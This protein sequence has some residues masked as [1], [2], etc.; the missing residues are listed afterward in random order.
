MDLLRV[1]YNISYMFCSKTDKFEASFKSNP[2]NNDVSDVH[3]STY[4]SLTIL[5][6]FKFWCWV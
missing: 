1:Y 2:M 3:V 6:M 5:A 4:T